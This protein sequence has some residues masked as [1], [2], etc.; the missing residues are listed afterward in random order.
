MD[1]TLIKLKEEVTYLVQ[2]VVDK[3]GLKPV[4]ITINYVDPTKVQG[5]SI[6]LEN[7]E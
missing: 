6:A 3:T 2:E 4:L 7:V 1:Q 5:V